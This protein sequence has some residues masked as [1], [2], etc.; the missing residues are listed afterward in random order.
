M[1]IS[2]NGIA[3]IFVLMTTLA[4][5][6][7]VGWAQDPAGDPGNAAGE[8]FANRPRAPSLQGGLGWLNSA[9]PI[10]LSKLRGKVVL[11]D[12]WTYC[13]IN[14]M[15]ILPD[16]AKLEKEFPNE[17]VVIGIH[18][19]KFDGEKD[20]QNIR[21]AI[22]RYEIK[23]PV[24]NDGQMTIW[25]RYGVNSW[26]TQVVIDPMGRYVGNV[27]GEGNYEVV[28]DVITQLVNFHRKRGT[29]DERPLHF[30]QETF[31]R[32][33]TPLLYPGKLLVDEASGRLFI[34]D[35]GHHRVVIAQMKTGKV[36][37]IIGTGEAGLQDG[38]FDQ[39]TFF[40]PQGLALVGNQILLADR[41]NHV[42]RQIDLDSRKVSTLAGTGVQGH[43][44]YRRGPAR[45]IP[46]ASPWDLLHRNGNLF[47]A[48]AGTHQIWRLDLATLEIAPF[49][50]NGRENIVDGDWES[51]NF[52]QP[53]G[54]SADDQFL[55]VADSETSS[56]R[57]IHWSDAT[58]E[59]VV[60]RGLFEF[61]DI[62][63]A[64][65]KARLQHAL[66][67]DVDP[68]SGLLYVADTYNNKIKTIKLETSR[69]NSFLGDGRGELSDDPPRFDEPS[70]VQVVGEELYVADTNNHA[71]RIVHKG[72][73]KTRTLSLEGL[74]PPPAAEESEDNEAK[75][76]DVPAVVLKPD[77]TILLRAEIQLSAKETLN[78]KAPMSYTLSAVDDAGQA[79]RI[80]RGRLKEIA[81]TVEFPFSSGDLRQASA[82]RVAIT[83]FPCDK[84]SAGVCR[85]VTK[86]WQIPISI[87]NDGTDQIAVTS[88]P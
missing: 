43:E 2:I 4:L 53:S 36:L 24:V 31:G 88:E 22:M 46:L 30:Q 50:G 5:P 67:V 85:I 78:P 49:A 81:P 75:P 72:T 66:G 65:D 13:C 82:L 17:L 33:A 63:G 15:H 29:L 60:G 7:S 19:A 68:K 20:S 76:I 62:D 51:A 69:T 57:K 27:S 55:Y 3:Q 56:I 47:I 16:L 38:A 10:E 35:S 14:C 70:D 86:T 79:K 42:I 34:S 74:E 87:S 80:G 6:A 32:E 84:E 64:P 48:M 37:D 39:A 21:D 12:F 83:Y 23:H 41:R 1:Q 44:R 28:R 18:S 9:G 73:K 59:T 25:R 61:G 54:L 40:E 71:I 52:A 26:P 58:V 8:P 45:E 11:L 77:Q